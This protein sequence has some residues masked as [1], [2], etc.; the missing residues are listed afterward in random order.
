MN[1]RKR[2]IT[3]ALLA[4]TAAC[5]TAPSD[6]PHASL[7]VYGVFIERSAWGVVADSWSAD[8]TGAVTHK[9]VDRLGP[10]PITETAK[11]FN[12]SSADFDAVLSILR[13]M[14]DKLVVGI[15]CDGPL[16]TDQDSVAIIWSRTG[17]YS[18]LNLY[19]GCSSPT[20]TSMREGY[21]KAIAFLR[22]LEARPDS[23]GSTGFT[24]APNRP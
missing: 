12:I 21:N 9:A 4:A 14:Q 7:P 5:T 16:P 10:S 1:R 23:A 22:S 6:Q 18:S 8:R 24:P 2:L 13:P 15:P 3:L 11:K 17:S 19:F 20:M